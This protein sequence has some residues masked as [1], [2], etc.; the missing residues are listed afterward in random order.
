[1]QQFTFFSN[2]TAFYPHF[3]DEGTERENLS[4]FPQIHSAN[5]GPIII[6]QIL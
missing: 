3:I 2:T 5:D 4:K 6:V 1:M